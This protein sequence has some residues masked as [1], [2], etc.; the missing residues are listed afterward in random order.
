MRRQIDRYMSL[1]ISRGYPDGIPD[2]VPAGLMRENLAPSYKAICIAIL[3]NDHSMSSLGF[4]GRKSGWYDYF[5]QVELANRA[6]ERKAD[7]TLQLSLLEG[8][9]RNHVK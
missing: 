6:G 4:S 5:K 9:S 7:V 2:E 1:W 3:S 8:Q